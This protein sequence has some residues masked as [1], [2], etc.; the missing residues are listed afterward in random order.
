MLPTNWSTVEKMLLQK[1]CKSVISQKIMN[2]PPPSIKP[3]VRVTINKQIDSNFY[4]T[5]HPNQGG[6]LTSLNDIVIKE[7]K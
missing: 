3:L 6:I 2:R 4:Q 1:F 7:V 5:F